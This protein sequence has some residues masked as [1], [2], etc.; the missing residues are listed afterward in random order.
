MG[1]GDVAAVVI[2]LHGRAQTGHG[3]IGD[4][5]RHEAI[6]WVAAVTSIGCGSRL[7]AIAVAVERHG[8]DVDLLTRHRS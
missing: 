8:M 3:L 6:R 5:P 2:H 4:R 7:S 1:P